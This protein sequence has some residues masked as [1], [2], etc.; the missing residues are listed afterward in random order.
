[1]RADATCRNSFCSSSAL[2]L[3]CG[4]RA[5]IVNIFL[6]GARAFTLLGKVGSSCVAVLCTPFDLSLSPSP[7]T[8]AESYRVSRVQR[9]GCALRCTVWLTCKHRARVFSFGVSRPAGRERFANH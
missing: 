8:G 2:V 3:A 9:S 6:T 1:V 5:R 4:W 7:A